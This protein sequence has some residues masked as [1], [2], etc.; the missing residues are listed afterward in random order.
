NPGLSGTI[1]AASTGR[2]D[3][4]TLSTESKDGTRIPVTLFLPPATRPC[5]VVVQVYGAYGISLEGPFDPFT[6]DLMSRGIA[7]AYCHVR[8]GGE[9]GPE[10]HRQA[11]GIHRERSIEDLFAGL[12]L[13]Q[14]H[15]AIAADRIVLSAASAGCLIA[16]T[17]C[18]REPTRLRGLQLVHPFLDPVTALMNS[19][20]RL[21]TTDW[22]EFGD[23]RNDDEVKTVLEQLS[24]IRIV[25]KMPHR[26]QRL[27]SAWIRGAR[28]DARVDTDAVERFSRLYR[29]ASC[30][31]EPGHVTCRIIEGGHL[32]GSSAN[33]AY[34]E[35]L[36]SHAWLIDTLAA[37][38]PG[39]AAWRSNDI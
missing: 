6:D 22:T 29:S 2:A 14:N 8:G 13:L 25:A 10:W 7:V 1:D 20:A 15:P 3:V 33:Q 11:W 5:G 16:A 19:G 9:N 32:G 38:S 27:P 26:S 34:E 23:P 36:L 21:T 39:M 17:A 30:A 31:T 28:C 4:Y 35:N 24:P 12:S 18:L 37:R